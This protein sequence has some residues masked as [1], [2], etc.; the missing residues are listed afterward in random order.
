MDRTLSASDRSALEQAAAREPQVR[1]W[2]RYRAVLL[3]AD[4]LTPAVVAE[5]LGCGISSVYDWLAR[6]RAAGVDGLREGPHPGA[7]PI[8]DADGVDCLTAL[9]ASSPQDH[10]HHA[11]GWTVPLLRTELAAVGVVLSD[12]TLRRTLHRLG[13]RWK[14]P[15]YVLGR[16]DPAYEEKRG[17]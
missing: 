9:L 5:V 10:G 7:A 1:R 15:Q 14:R 16:P 6:W 4:G 3:V 12:T 11:T 17:A 8:L 13:Y 2:R